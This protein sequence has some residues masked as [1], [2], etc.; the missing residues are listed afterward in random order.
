MPIEVKAYKC[1]KCKKAYLSEKVAED[2][3]K[4]VPKNNTCRVCG[5]EVK[6]P[7]MICDYCKTQEYYDK[8]KKI[9]YKDYKVAMFY[10]EDTDKYYSDIDELME[11]I[12]NRAF[13]DGIP[14]TEVVYPEW[15]F[16]CKEIPFRIGV[17]HM[18]EIASEE[19]YE[20]FEYDRDV[21]DLKELHEFIEQWNQ[22]QTA[23][24]YVPD[25]KTVVIFG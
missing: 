11:D 20:E 1:E 25:Y 15:A 3:C 13:D 4:D 5:V 10:S 8:A 2:C 9:P 6:K 22:K 23:K 17:D 24:A 21:V 18:L 16:G 14:E 7:W 12:D 19:M